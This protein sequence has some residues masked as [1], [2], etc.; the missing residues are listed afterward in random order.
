[1]PQPRPLAFATSVTVI[2]ALLAFSATG[3]HSPFSGIIAAEQPV[4][5]A[6]LDA[7]TPA[8]DGLAFATPE[9]PSP[10]S[11]ATPSAKP[12]KRDGGGQPTGEAKDA[13]PKPRATPGPTPRKTHAPP[14]PTAAPTAT[15]R[16]TPKPTSAPPADQPDLSVQAGDNGVDLAW[17]SCS[18][19]AFAAYAVVRSA[20][21]EI[22]YPPEDR[23][24]LV[25]LVT[26]RA[27]TSVL[28]TGAPS[29]GRAWYR[30]WCLSRHDGEYKSIWS[31]PTRSVT[32]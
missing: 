22:H 21:S 15:A 24:S 11:R 1:M 31:T 6:D 13:K 8:D 18:S 32:P 27:T 28:D 23:D 25:A 29:G 30:V 10:G 9:P 20:D 26:S 5:D 2:A 16:P 3:G 14:T 19:S 4:S 17:T 12:S 7:P